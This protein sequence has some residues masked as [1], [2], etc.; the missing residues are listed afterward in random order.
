MGQRGD[1][2]GEAVEESGEGRGWEE[3]Y[4]DYLE[5]ASTEPADLH[6]YVDAAA[7]IAG[8]DDIAFEP[9][10]D[11]LG[12]ATIPAL[13]LDA[14]DRYRITGAN[15]VQLN[16]KYLE[17]EESYDTFIG[18]VNHELAHVFQFEDIG[19]RNEY[20][21]DDELDYLLFLQEGQ[22]A[23]NADGKSHPFAR[24]FY[25][26]FYERYMEEAKELI[27]ESDELTN[28]S[29]EAYKEF[30][31]G[32]TL[33]DLS[34]ENYLAVVE[35]GLEDGGDAYQNMMLDRDD[36]GELDEDEI[37]E[38]ADDLFLGE[39]DPDGSYTVDFRDD[40]IDAH[41]LGKHLVDVQGD[42]SQYYE[43]LWEEG[44]DLPLGAVR[45]LDI[46]SVSY[47]EKGEESG[48][49]DIEAF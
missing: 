43:E 17:G 27:E 19:E 22:A 44:Y 30:A 3:A 32:E 2:Y 10:P 12:G 21:S 15:R 33:K 36:V 26:E 48:L 6:D 42:L 34:E 16:E 45:N 39:V 47:G 28:E 31:A 4:L 1:L 41:K 40:D 7:D 13:E 24:E 35:L 14:D 25:G 46:D 49:V 8:F 20:F 5:A 38:L 18:T 29:L 11:Y 23:Y 9:L 37:Y